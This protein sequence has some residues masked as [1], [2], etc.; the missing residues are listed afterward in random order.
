MFLLKTILTCFIFNLFCSLISAQ[1][2]SSYSHSHNDY[3]QDA[4]LFDALDNGM[5][6]IEIDVCLDGNNLKVSHDP[7]ML[8][9][10]KTLEE[11]YLDPLREWIKLS[12]GNVYQNDTTPVVLM[13]DLKGN[14]RK[15]YPVL[16]RILSN[17]EDIIT[18]YYEDSIKKGPLEIC[19]SGSKPYD[20][21]SKEKIRYV[22]IDGNINSDVYSEMPPT[23]LQRVSDPWGK[24]FKWRGIGK[25]PDKQKKMLHELVNNA[26]KYNREIR[27]YAAG[28]NKNL[29][30][31]LLDAG[32]DWINVDKL[33]KYRN[34]Y[35]KYKKG[36]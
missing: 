31:E 15:S 13:I 8:N 2:P 1:E 19:V 27:F 5:K 28:N 34:F 17:Y 23:I 16:H 32:V 22:T 7:L 14:G 24:F 29:W 33:S 11:Q 26:H 4:P 21:I 36:N 9:L 12:G 20:L 6:S 30:K 25:M 35:K 3:M 18:V 10:K